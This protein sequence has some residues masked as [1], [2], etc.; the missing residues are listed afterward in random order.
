[1]GQVFRTERQLILCAYML[2]FLFYLKYLLQ[3]WSG[4]NE[5]II[6]Q[7]GYVILMVGVLFSGIAFLLASNKEKISFI[8]LLII[9]CLAIF[10]YGNKYYF[11]C[12]SAYPLVIFYSRLNDEKT[13]SV[14]LASILSAWLIFIPFQLLFSTNFFFHDDRYIRLSLGFENPNTFAVLLFVVYSLI[15]AF[16]DRRR[17]VFG[18]AGY[19]IASLII[20]PLVYLTMSRTFLLTSLLLCA[21]FPFRQIRLL[22]IHAKFATIILILIACFQFYLVSG[23]GTH[24]PASYAFDS[25]FSGRVRLSYQMY[26]SLGFPGLF[27]GSDISDYLPI[28]FFFPNLLFSSGWFFSFFYIIFY[29]YI[30][31]NLKCKTNFISFLC[32]IMI[33]LSLAENVFNIPIINYTIF[34]LYKSREIKRLYMK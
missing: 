9:F 16:L 5:L 24:N 28:D 6:E 11:W 29:I 19:I 14:L 12:L 2:T 34:F 25:L 10:L 17:D 33:M 15:L 21:Y 20:L 3:G 4:K 8:I 32:L 31:S 23:Y 13:I 18:G 1:M 22:K 30:L 7:V 27:L 26:A